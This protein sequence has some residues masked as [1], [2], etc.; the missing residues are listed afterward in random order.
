MSTPMKKGWDRDH[1][2]YTCADRT[3]IVSPRALRAKYSTLTPYKSYSVPL[4]G[5][6]CTR[7]WP[8]ISGNI[9]NRDISVIITGAQNAR[10]ATFPSTVRK[11]SEDAFY[12]RERL[13]SA[14]V[15]EGI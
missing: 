7:Q 8:V 13:R 5:I 9:F 1:G 10:T 4:N 11:V 6:L 12:R 2:R 15:N 3:E 14:M